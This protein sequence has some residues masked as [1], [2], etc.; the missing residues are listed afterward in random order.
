MQTYILINSVSKKIYF[1]ELRSSGILRSVEWLSFTDVS[2]QRICPIFKGQEVQEQKKRFFF[3]FLTLD[4]GAYT[5]SRNVGKGFT[6][7]RCVISQKSAD[8]IN[9]LTS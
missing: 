8:L 6:I 5:L 4:D 2:W 9:I 1:R 7:R 3:D